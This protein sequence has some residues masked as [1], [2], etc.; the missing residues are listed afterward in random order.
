MSSQRISAALLAL[1]LPGCLSD[2]SDHP[3]VWPPDDFHLEVESG[4]Y[5]QQA[6]QVL[7]RFQ[8]WS[9][10][11]ALYREADDSVRD[12]AGEVSLP[13]FRRICAW[14]MLPESTRSLARKLYRRG[15]LDLHSIQGDQR[16]RAEGLA[17]VLRYRAFGRGKNVVA[18]GQ[19]HGPMVRVLHVVNSY[20]PEGVEFDLPGMV[21]DREPQRLT[22]VPPPTDDLEGS[23]ELHRELLERFSEDPEL[24]L[25]AFALACRAGR[26]DVAEQLMT[27]YLELTEP[28]R[29]QGEMFPEGGE[30]LT[31]ER[32]RRLLPADPGARGPPR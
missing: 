18:R 7:Q 4:R 32:L 5:T 14:R 11:L 26:R 29:R 3:T 21:G 22:D 6:S 2:P 8:V 13:V 1:L 16:Q 27:R 30:G 19:I 25:D 23:L 17:L 28:A 24:T 15:V 31:A 9:D 10:G 20:L 12:P